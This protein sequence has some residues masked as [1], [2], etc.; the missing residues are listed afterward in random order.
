MNFRSVFGIG[1]FVGGFFA[2]V[3][4]A[5]VADSDDAWIPAA[6]FFSGAFGGLLYGTQSGSLLAMS[7]EGAKVQLGTLGDVLFGIAGAIVA[8]V[9]VPGE[10]V[11]KD[12][13]MRLNVVGVAILGGYAGR[14]LVVAG[15][16]KTLG[17]IEGRTKRLESDAKSASDAQAVVSA[18]LTMTG[19]DPDQTERALSAAIQNAPESVRLGIL[20]QVQNVRSV[21]FRNGTSAEIE[22]TIP[23]FRALL[24]SEPAT[25][26]NYHRYL[27]QL[28]YAL[29]DQTNPDWEQSR[30]LLTQAIH[31]RG[32]TGTFREY[33]FNRAVCSL[34]LGDR[35]DRELHDL[36][37]AES[38]PRWNKLKSVE[39]PTEEKQTIGEC[40]DALRE[41][42]TS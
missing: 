42:R 38:H 14:A 20:A 22:R 2:T 16:Q 39:L 40:L 29:K 9:I 6:V 26:A 30:E 7:N 24:E 12:V 15:V 31:V 1:V 32:P 27:A 35:G 17:E 18:Q 23:I 5:A 13:W 37:V 11:A 36:E 33:E 3:F 28:A 19:E 10:F 21:A 41:R 4:F 8:F 34:A 25:S